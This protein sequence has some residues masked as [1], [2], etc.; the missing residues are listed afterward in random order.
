[1]SNLDKKPRV[2]WDTSKPL[3]DK[4]RILDISRARALGWEPKVSLEQGI[5]ETMDW[6][7]QYQG[8][9]TKRY[10]V[11]APGGARRLLPGAR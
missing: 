10:D 5:K 11:F 8:E 7:R 3:G 1:M 6:F 9:T 4:M 2:V